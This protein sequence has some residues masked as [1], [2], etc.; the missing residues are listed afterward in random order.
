MSF[1]QTPPEADLSRTETVVSYLINR[2]PILKALE[3]HGRILSEIQHA[4][5]ARVGGHG[6]SNESLD[7]TTQ[8]N[9]YIVALLEEFDPELVDPQFNGIYDEFEALLAHESDK[10]SVMHRVGQA[11]LNCARSM[12]NGFA[13]ANESTAQPIRLF[14]GYPY[15]LTHAKQIV[16]RNVRK[17]D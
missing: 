17:R 2:I 11:A 4:D 15:Q 13:A 3:D 12:G 16:S 5:A 14:F 6:L 9:P 10:K 1:E 8:E 7:I